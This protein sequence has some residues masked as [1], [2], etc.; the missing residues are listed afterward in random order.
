MFDTGG[1]AGQL[2]RATALITGATAAITPEMTGS[3]AGEALREAIA[4]DQQLTLTICLLT[5]R[6]APHRRILSRRRRLHVG[7]ATH[8]SPLHP[9][10][11]LS[12]DQ[13]REAARRL[14]AQDPGRVGCRN[15][16]L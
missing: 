7:M 8:R 6:V 4:A 12:P 9:S 15:P 13:N 16:E 5:E 3:E 14:A 1:M 2:E 10:L 11:G